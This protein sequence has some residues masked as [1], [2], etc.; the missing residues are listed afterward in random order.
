MLALH[1]FFWITEIIP[2]PASL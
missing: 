2:Y 1:Q